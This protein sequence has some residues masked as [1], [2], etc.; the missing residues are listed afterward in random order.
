MDV[1]FIKKQAFLDSEIL[2]VNLNDPKLGW[3]DRQLLETIGEKLYGK[4]KPVGG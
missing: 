2:V 3:A 4:R 1:A